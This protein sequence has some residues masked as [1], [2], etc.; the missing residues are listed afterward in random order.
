MKEILIAKLNG[1]TEVSTDVLVSVV[2]YMDDVVMRMNKR[3]SQLEGLGEHKDPMAVLR[4]SDMEAV[5]GT[6]LI[7]LD[8][9]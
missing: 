9:N 1:K 2:E 8:A 5:F 7:T 3:N 6:L 4:I